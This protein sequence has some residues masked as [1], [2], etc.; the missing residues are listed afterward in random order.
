MTE[1]GQADK[2]V[3]IS[4]PSGVGKSTICRRLVEELDA[5]LSVSMT[6]RPRRENEVDGRDYH[7]VSTETF[8]RERARGALLEHAQV[9]GGHGY[10]TP[11]EPVGEALAAGRVAILEIEIN[12]AEQVVRRYP[13]A[14][15]VYIL[16]PTAEDQEE[17]LV[18][19]RNDSARAIAER[20]GKAEAEIR[21]ARACGAYR[22]FVVNDVIEDTVRQIVRLI[23]EKP[24]S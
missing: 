14:I 13:E 22:Y 24:L 18:G 16:A 3:I 11:A 17:R 12:G 7:F 8:E 6:T 9:Y 20:L 2:L 23:R 19:R 10:G 21:H 4:G 1:S 5:F 15:G